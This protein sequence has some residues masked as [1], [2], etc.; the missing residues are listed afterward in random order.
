MYSNKQLHE[1]KRKISNKHPH[2]THKGTN[3]KKKVLSPKLEEG[4][5]ITKIREK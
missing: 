2:C 4:K 1:E 5:T 3:K